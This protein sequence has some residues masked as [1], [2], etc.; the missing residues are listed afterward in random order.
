MKIE[1]KCR[2]CV[3]IKSNKNKINVKSLDEELEELIKD[4]N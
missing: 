2:N 4:E 1:T 3:E